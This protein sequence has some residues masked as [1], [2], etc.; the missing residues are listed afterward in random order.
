MDVK[1]AVHAA[2]EYIAELYEDEQ[3][4]DM[5][6]E[7]VVFE[8]LPAV[9]KVTIGF[10]RPWDV[11]GPAIAALVDARRTRSYKVISLNDASGKVESLTDRVLEKS[12][13]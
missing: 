10:S 5:G 6:L 1:Q 7:E 13:R 9:W 4:I 12:G 2:K 11:K 8:E 3:I